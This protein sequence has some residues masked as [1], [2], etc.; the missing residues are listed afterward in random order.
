ML[1]RDGGEGGRVVDP[2]HLPSV[3]LYYNTGIQETEDK[4][5]TKFFDFKNASGQ[6]TSISSKMSNHKIK[7]RG[8][9]ETFDRRMEM[10]RRRV[11]GVPGCG[12]EESSRERARAKAKR[13][14]RSD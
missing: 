4:P 1:P 13:E 5:Y 11:R 2:N 9:K 10:L 14:L 8:R 7:N 12:A 6:E 3:S